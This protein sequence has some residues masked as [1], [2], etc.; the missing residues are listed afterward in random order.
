MLIAETHFTNRSYIKIPN[1]QIYDTKH[2]DDTDHGGTAIVIKSSIKH[3]ELIEFKNDY[4]LATSVQ[5]ED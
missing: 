1:Y 3:H 5:I 4:L 2:P